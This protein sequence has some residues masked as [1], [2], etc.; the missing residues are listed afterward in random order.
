MRIRSTSAPPTK[1]KKMDNI[2]YIRPSFLWSTVITHECRISSSAFSCSRGGVRSSEPWIGSVWSA[3]FFSLLQRF[4]VSGD[5]V[6][7]FVGQLH[8]RHQDAGLETVRTL[9]P[10]PQIVSG[11]RDLARCKRVATH[12]MC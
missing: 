8:G 2:M 3:I 6:E 4:Q 11:I 1:R 10:L 12:Q 7:L 5:L 9:D